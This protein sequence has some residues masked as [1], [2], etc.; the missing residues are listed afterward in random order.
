LSNRG[1]RAIVCWRPEEWARVSRPGPLRWQPVAGRQSQLVSRHSTPMWVA[2]I[3]INARDRL[4]ATAAPAPTNHNDGSQ[5]KAAEREPSEPGQAW[6]TGQPEGGGGDERGGQTLPVRPSAR[7]EQK[8]GRSSC[9]RSA[10]ARVRDLVTSS[11]R[12]QSWLANFQYVASIAQL[13][14]RA[15]HASRR[16]NNQFPS[17]PLAP[18]CAPAPLV[19]APPARPFVA[20]GRPARLGSARL[21]SA[22]LGST[23]LDSLASPPIGAAR[24]PR[25]G[26]SPISRRA[27]R[28]KLAAYSSRAACVG[29][30]LSRRAKA[31]PAGRPTKTNSGRQAQL[32]SQLFGARN[33]WPSLAALARP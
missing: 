26:S 17:P 7:S 28:A 4:L 25:A 12:Q 11:D 27:G 2:Q 21:G 15:L 13:E 16:R 29:V 22:R 1:R 33:C 3:D 19:R 18:I 30:P 5:E 8:R 6:P 32:A 23:R 31:L 10:R 20:G 9:W 14:S 24:A